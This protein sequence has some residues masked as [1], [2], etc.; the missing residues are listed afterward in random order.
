VSSGVALDARSVYFLARL[1]PRYPTVEIRVADVS[2]TAG[3]AVGYV[4]LVRALVARALDESVLGRPV[5]AVAQGPLRES[6]RS[7]ARLGLGGSVA[8]P[9]TGET[10]DSWALVDA[11]FAQVAPQLRAQGDEA[12]VAS[13]LDRLRVSGGGAERQRRLFTEAG[14]PTCFVEELAAATAG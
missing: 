12:L 4:G 1:S 11:L 5:A 14:S 10:V 6:C 13:T 3:D 7:A 2:L 8:D 9:Q